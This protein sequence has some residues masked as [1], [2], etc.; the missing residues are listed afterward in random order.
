MSEE[1]TPMR[2]RTTGDTPDRPIEE[3]TDPPDG[4][5]P[6]RS[7]LKSGAIGLA[8]VAATPGSPVAPVFTP[9]ADAKD[10]IRHVD[11]KRKVLRGGVVLSLDPAVGDFERA[12]VVIEGKKIVSVSPSSGG[13]GGR[14]NDR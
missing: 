4:G 10:V 7:F 1:G 12:D 11:R 14:T 6:R 3:G 13:G 8:A 9:S 5:T 2:K